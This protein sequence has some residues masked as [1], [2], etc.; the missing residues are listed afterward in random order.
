M[1]SMNASVSRMAFSVSCEMLRPPTVTGQALGAQ[2]IAVARPARDLAHELLDLLARR[3]RVRLGVPTLEVREHAF[4]GGVVR[5]LSVVP[6]LVSDVHLFV[7]T[8]EH[9]VARGLR[10]LLPGR[11]EREPVCLGHRLQTRYQY[12]NVL[13]AHGAI[14]P[15]VDREV[16]VGDDELRVDLELD[17][18]PVARLARAVRAS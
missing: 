8:V 13:L 9:H 11:V 14:A 6:V 4:I 3:V 2:A 18:E 7:R 17:P 16:G 15:F 5:A 12:S 1:P 10:Q